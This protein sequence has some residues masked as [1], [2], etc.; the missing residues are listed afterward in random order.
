MKILLVD[1]S[2][3]MRSVLKRALAPLAGA[4]PVTE[5]ADGVA[6]LDVIA[7]A[8]GGFDV[9]LIDWNMPRMDG[10][11]LARRI[12]ETDPR[13]PL[14]VCATEAERPRV[15]EALKSGVNAYV[16]KPFNPDEL[17]AKVKQT[18]EKAR[19]AHAAA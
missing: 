9:I 15:A 19:A 7:R 1:D 13:T 18:V 5:A 6:A 12:R 11:A 10:L 17:R 2:R 16:I 8:P 14:I 3:P 4:T